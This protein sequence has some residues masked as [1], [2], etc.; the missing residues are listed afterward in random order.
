LDEQAVRNQAKLETVLDP[1]P[2][3]ATQQAYQKRIS[4]VTEVAVPTRFMFAIRST[5]KKETWDDALMMMAREKDRDLK[6][7]G[8]GCFWMCVGHA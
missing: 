5:Q 3:H 2:S 8:F 6:I 1:H 4:Q 7:G